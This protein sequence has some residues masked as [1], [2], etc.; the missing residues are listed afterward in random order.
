MAKNYELTQFETFYI[1]KIFKWIYT[2]SL[3]STCFKSR[4]VRRSISIFQRANSIARENTNTLI[5][6]SNNQ[7][8]R[9][10]RLSKVIS[11][12][13]IF[14]LSYPTGTELHIY[15]HILPP[16]YHLSLSIQQ[17]I[18]SIIKNIKIYK[19]S[20]DSVCGYIF[21]FYYIDIDFNKSS[22]LLCLCG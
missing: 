18:H 4:K 16:K 11:R 14:N 7:I 8:N 19:K 1:V 9:K 6:R 17:R 21:I 12:H 10:L 20:N 5:R 22:F 3:K 13:N 2:L 15:S